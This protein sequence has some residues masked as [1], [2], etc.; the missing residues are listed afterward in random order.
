MIICVLV[1]LIN[2]NESQDF[3]EPVRLTGSLQWDMR[4]LSEL[5]RKPGDEEQTACKRVHTVNMMDLTQLT[6]ES[7]GRSKLHS[8]AR[9][10]SVPKNNG[11]L[12]HCNI[13]TCST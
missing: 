7:R 1:V 6:G 5:S 11:T 2:G 12:L 8:H 10:H 4:R 3:C 9:K 13:G